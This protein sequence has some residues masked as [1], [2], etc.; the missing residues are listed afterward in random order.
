[1]LRKSIAK[2][3]FNELVGAAGRRYQFKELLQERPFLGRVWLATSENTPRMIHNSKA[4][5]LSDPDK[6][7]L[8]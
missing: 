8:S 7:S 1:M 2:L 3:A 6:I 5:T 4:N